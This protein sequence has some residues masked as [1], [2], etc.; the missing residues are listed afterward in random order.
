MIVLYIGT[1]F[2]SPQ[3]LPVKHGFEKVFL[4]FQLL[5]T[6]GD[7]SKPFKFFPY[8]ESQQFCKYRWFHAQSP[9]PSGIFLS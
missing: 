8:V 7:S 3:Y 5:G 1:N 2:N 9:Y 6:K 4:D